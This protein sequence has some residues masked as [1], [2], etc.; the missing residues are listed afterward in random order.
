VRTRSAVPEDAE[1]IVHIYNQGTEV[2]IATFE[3]RPRSAEEI[4]SWFGGAHPIVVVEGNRVAAFAATSNCRPRECY[5]GVAEF[6]IYPAHWAR[7]LGAGGLAMKALIEAAER[8]GFWKL[9][10]RVFVENRLSRKLLYSVGFREVGV[11]EK[12]ARLDGEWRDVVIVERVVGRGPNTFLLNHLIATMC[13]VLKVSKSG[14]HAWRCRPPSMRT[15]ADMALAERIERIHRESK[16]TYG[17][18]RVDAELRLSGVRCAKKR[19][20]RLMREAGLVALR[21]PRLQR[22]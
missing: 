4:R 15:R 12:H 22:R 17:A 19:V 5:A 14:Y 16:G 2:R 18:P 10:S 21:Q 1:T 8:A 20:A 7:S 11:Y 9:V 13:M 3:T 6:S